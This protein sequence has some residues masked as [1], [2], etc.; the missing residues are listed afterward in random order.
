MQD[1]RRQAFRHQFHIVPRSLPQIAAFAKQIMNLKCMIPSRP[2]ESE[3]E[4]NPSC[5]GV[6]RIE[7]DDDNDDVGKIV[8]RFAVTNQRWVIGAVEAQIAIALQR[9]ILFANPIDSGDQIPSSSR[10]NQDRDA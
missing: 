8:G 4:I 7:I 6:E 1:V 9:R 10:R 2:S 3:V 5:L